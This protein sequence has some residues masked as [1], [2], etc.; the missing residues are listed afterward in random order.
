MDYVSHIIP[1]SP[2]VEVDCS[3]LPKQVSCLTNGP[4]YV[5]PCQSRF[6]HQTTIDTTIARKYKNLVKCFEIGLTKNSMSYSD[7][8][9][10]QFFVDMEN[11]LRQLY[12]TPLSPKLFARAQNEYRIIKSIQRQIKKSNVI[13]RSTDK[14]KVLHLG[15]AHEYH[16]KVLQYMH[17]TKAYKEITNGINPCHDHI[18]KVLTIIDSMLKKGDINLQLWKQYMRPNATTAELAH[19]YFIPKPHKVNFT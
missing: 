7:Q 4:K 11:L 18:Q 17:D 15:S 5:P 13:I 2:I 3:L 9:A 8:R 19:L 12:T 1:S 14:S 16:Q 10:K 6:P